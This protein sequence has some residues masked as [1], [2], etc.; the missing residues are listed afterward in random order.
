VARPQGRLWLP[1]ISRNPVQR[2]IALAKDMHIVIVS[3]APE[4]SERSGGKS[5]RY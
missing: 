4:R 3:D 1:G 5:L 2:L